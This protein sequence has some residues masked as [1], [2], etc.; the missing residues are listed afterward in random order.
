MYATYLSS[1]FSVRHT[2][3]DAAIRMAMWRQSQIRGGVE[4]RLRPLVREEASPECM[5]RTL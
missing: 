2:L 1:Y 5:R 3:C 4:R